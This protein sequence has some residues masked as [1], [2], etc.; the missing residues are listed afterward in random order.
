M[1]N[2]EFRRS[3]SHADS[4]A[5]L[6]NLLEAPRR[7][8]ERTGRRC[9]VAYDEFQEM[10]TAQP[11]LDGVLRSHIQHH[12]GAVSYLFAGSHTDMMDALFGDR[13]RPLFEQARPVRIGPLASANIADH[14]EA[15][16]SAAQRA[17][18]PDLPTPSQGSPRPS[19]ARHDDRPL[20][21]GAIGSR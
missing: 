15:H 16:F 6:H 12:T 9:L 7:L 11:D 4:L 1:V 13:R 14:I 21:L 19:P 20:P 3:A 2:V 18:D 17:L 5:R 10:L 8:H